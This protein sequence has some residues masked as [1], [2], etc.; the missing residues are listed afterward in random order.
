M[1][2]IKG[3][4]LSKIGFKHVI[5]GV[6]LSGEKESYVLMTPNNELKPKLKEIGLELEEWEKV[7]KQMDIMQLEV[8]QGEHLSK[9]ILRKSQRN[10]ESRISWRVFRRD[11]FTCRYC[12]NN[13]S[14]M[15]VDHLRLWEDG[16]PSI[17][18]NLLTSCKKC[19]RK[20]GNLPYKE[21]LQTDYYK[22]VSKGLDIKILIGNEA[23]VGIIEHIPLNKHKRK[24]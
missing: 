7:L 18:T 19:N 20:R 4:D 21:W 23:L 1:E 13:K 6:V 9:V 12:G 8:T 14:P 16:G 22:E 24:R 3:L 10:I 11:N 5:T 2:I 15:T 17:V